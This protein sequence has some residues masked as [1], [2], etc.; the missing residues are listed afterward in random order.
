MDQEAKDIKV[1]KEEILMAENLS[2]KTVVQKQ[3]AF[4]A[5]KAIEASTIA[6]TI[7]NAAYEKCL[8]DMDVFRY[9]L[10]DKYEIDFEKHELE[11]VTGRVIAKE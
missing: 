7:A 10:R 1:T 2:L 3:K 4:A 6:L 11:A 9:M 8:K 5:E